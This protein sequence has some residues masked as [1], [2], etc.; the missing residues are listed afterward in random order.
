MK[1][2]LYYVHAKL[3]AVKRKRFR[4]NRYNSFEYC[5]ME[6]LKKKPLVTRRKEKKADRGI[7][8]ALNSIKITEVF[9]TVQSLFDGKQYV[10]KTCQLIEALSINTS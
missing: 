8:F 7:D 3:K 9:F 4:G 1:Y 10:C 5:E 2:T 6:P